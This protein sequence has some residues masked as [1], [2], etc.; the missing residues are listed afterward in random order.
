MKRLSA[1]IKIRTESDMVKAVERHLK[2]KGNVV[3]WREVKLSGGRA[4]LVAYDKNAKLFKIIECKMHS[5]PINSGKTFGQATTYLSILGG[6]VS[7]F[8]DVISK[9]NDSPP[10]RFSRWME[11]TSN[12][13]KIRVEVFVAL[14]EKATM[15]PKFRNLRSKF[16]EI[17]VIR[18]K[19]SGQCRDTLRRP[20]GSHDPKAARA[21]L[22]IL[23]L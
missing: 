8:L 12:G 14:T 10:M 6:E 23:P 17:G 22:T 15:Q 16:P 1:G 9:K 19:Q 21:Q 13:K 11:A 20:D 4:D 7:K 18:V 3:V 5:K 2:N